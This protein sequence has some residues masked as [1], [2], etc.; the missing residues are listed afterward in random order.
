MVYLYSTGV[1]NLTEGLY[2]RS[3][4]CVITTL[5]I[6]F[7][8]SEMM[9]SVTTSDVHSWWGAARDLVNGEFTNRTASAVYCLDA[10]PSS[11]IH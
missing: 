4:K 6:S 1:L 10:E 8:K 3:I 2:P 9:T 11:E 5:S 7:Q